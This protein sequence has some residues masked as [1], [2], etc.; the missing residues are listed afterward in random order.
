MQELAG[1]DQQ[2][3]RL[4]EKPCTGPLERAMPV[5]HAP[6][7]LAAAMSTLGERVRQRRLEL[8]FSQ[9]DLGVASGAYISLVEQDA[10]QPSGKILRKLAV[11]LGV[12]LYWLET[13]REDP[14][15]RLARLVL[16]HSCPSLDPD[17]HDLAL[18][19]LCQ[20]HWAGRAPVS[21]PRPRA[22]FR[23][24]GT[25]V[26]AARMRLLVEEVAAGSI[27]EVAFGSVANPRI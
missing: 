14:A 1:V 12:S 22:E 24:E 3:F 10:R 18:S 26:R 2:V 23:R 21:E 16:D 15:E 9:A 25:S 27:G 5:T 6:G 17:A 11:R 20:R 8:G 7:T 19:V 13:G 4:A